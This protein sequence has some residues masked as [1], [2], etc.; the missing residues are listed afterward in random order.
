MRSRPRCPRAATAIVV[1]MLL[2]GACG[3][4]S[5]DPVVTDVLPSSATPGA[6]LLLRGRDLPSNGEVLIGDR[7][8]AR[9]TWVSTDLATA[10]LPADLAPGTYPLRVRFPRG[11]DSLL[12]LT[13]V[14]PA[15]PAPPVTAAPL[16]VPTAQ[17][18]PEPPTGPPPA[19][20][21]PPFRPAGAGPGEK[22]DDD[23][24]RKEPARPDNKGRG[25]GRGR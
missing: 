10:L 1:A 13:V 23:D 25:R 20:Q 19:L 21:V 15:S 12:F 3:T 16:P 5:S 9:V 14:K 2:A 6:F 17:A 8:A 11:H 18:A 7:A 4:P 24:A 22:A